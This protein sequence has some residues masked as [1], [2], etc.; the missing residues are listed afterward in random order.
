MRVLLLCD[1]VA[2]D[3]GFAAVGRAAVR[4]FR[5]R[6]WSVA[7]VALFD[8]APDCDSRPYWEMGVRPYFPVQRGTVSGGFLRHALST[9]EPDVLV[10]IRD[11]G[12]AATFYS[13]EWG[14]YADQLPTVLYAPL[15]G[16]PVLREFREAFGA[17]TVAATYTEW[18]SGRL[19]EEAG[20]DVPAYLHGVDAATFYPWESP[21]YRAEARR[22]L[23]WDDKFVVMYCARNA[24]RKNHDRLLRAAKLLLDAGMDDLLL[25]LHTTPFAGYSLGGWDLPQVAHYAGVPSEHVQYARQTDPVRGEEAGSLRQKYASADVYVH[26]AAVEGFGLPILEAMACGCPVVV[27]DDGGNMSEVA[28]DAAFA[29]IRVRDWETWFTGAQLANCAPEDIA[30]M[31]IEARRHPD[32]LA[33]RAALGRERA[34][35]LPWEPMGEGVADAC[36][37]AVAAFGPRLSVGEVA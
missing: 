29:R 13:N 14:P 30:G 21:V 6:G 8:E 1:G 31:I 9:F 2:L 28:G 4:A 24:K 26:V 36:V 37:R 17:A 12:S 10:L 19:R 20:L 25:Y 16:A 23:G 33:Q 22:L 7:Q 15:E 11:P 3:T 18:A 27:P 35:T 34:L 32:L 5:E